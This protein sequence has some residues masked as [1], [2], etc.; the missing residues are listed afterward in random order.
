[1]KSNIE[2]DLRLA[3]KLLN[4]MV[5]EARKEGI[6]SIELM[7]IIRLVEHEALEIMKKEFNPVWDKVVK[8]D[9]K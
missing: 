6:P 8:E 5:D 1:M 9:T 2:R 7:G 4:Y 3:N